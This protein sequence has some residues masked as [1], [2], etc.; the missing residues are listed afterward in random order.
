MKTLSKFIKESV[1]IENFD[2]KSIKLDA[3]DFNP[4]IGVSAFYDQIILLEGQ[5]W[6]SY[7]SFMVHVKTKVTRNHGDYDNEEFD[8]V[9]VLSV[10]AE[11]NYIMVD[12]IKIEIGE[13]DYNE[14]LFNELENMIA[15]TV[16]VEIV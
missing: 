3:S 4:G 7:I 9:E 14:S 15:A 11:V 8:E 13:D 2:E 10:T 6:E 16:V 1:K 12:G 5:E